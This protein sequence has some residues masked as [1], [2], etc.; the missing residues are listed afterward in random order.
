MGRN[1]V[2]NELRKN[3]ESK[4]ITPTLLNSKPLDYL[5]N[6]VEHNDLTPYKTILSY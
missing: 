4:E 2:Y 3:K 1:A 5:E 6:Y